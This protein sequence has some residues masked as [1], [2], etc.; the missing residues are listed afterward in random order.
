[1][2][3]IFLGFS[4]GRTQDLEQIFSAV[5][6]YKLSR[7]DPTVLNCRVRNIAIIIIHNIKVLRI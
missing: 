2:E 5:N 1:M 6:S 3:I 7:S 4:K